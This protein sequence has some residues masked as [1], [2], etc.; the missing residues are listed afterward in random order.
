MQTRSSNKNPEGQEAHRAIS[1]DF[2][3]DPS[4]LIPA[5]TI[6]SSDNQKTTTDQHQTEGT[7]VDSVPFEEP[8]VDSQQKSKD[9]VLSPSFKVE[10]M[11]AE[12]YL[13]AEVLQSPL[14]TLHTALSHQIGCLVNERFQATAWDEI[15]P[16]DQARLDCWT[17]NAKLLIESERGHKAIFQAWIWH[18]IDDGVFSADPDT[19]WQEHDERYEAIK[20]FSKFLAT[21]QSTYLPIFVF[22]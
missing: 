2:T 3:P 7:R 11:P 1:P 17:P 6:E 18:I 13:A 16:K 4:N 20:L 21:I 15:N 9:N 5:S 14:H 19:K 12:N 10:E 22:L 8:R